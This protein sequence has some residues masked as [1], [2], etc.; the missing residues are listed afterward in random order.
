MPRPALLLQPK[1][2][3]T[4]PVFWQVA[5]GHPLG[6]GVL[7]L[8]SE[9]FLFFVTQIDPVEEIGGLQLDRDWNCFARR[10]ERG[11]VRTGIPRAGGWLPGIASGPGREL[12]PRLCLDAHVGDFSY[13]NLDL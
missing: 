9:S 1:G 10:S 3:R 6:K 2:L 5:D 12:S 4:R 11:A 7:V 13:E 8:V